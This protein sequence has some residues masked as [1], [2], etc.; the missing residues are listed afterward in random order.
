MDNFKNWY[1]DRKGKYILFFGFYLFFFIFLSIYMR[2]L[3]NNQNEEISVEPTPM[4]ITTYDISNLINN[5]Y[6]YAIEILDNEK[7]I[8]FS[9]SKNNVDYANFDNKYFFDIYNINQL[10]KRSKL[11]NSENNILTYE[12]ENKELNDILLT[13]QNDGVNTISV[14]VNDK[15][16]VIKIV[17]DL[18]N[19]LNKDKYEITINYEMGESNEN[20]SS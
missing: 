15:A 6:N 12:L 4:I 11:I 17:I 3:N 2:N 19:Y 5:D 20:S 18:S 10:L 14:Y 16:E 13:N 9:G 8:T 7:T 1:T